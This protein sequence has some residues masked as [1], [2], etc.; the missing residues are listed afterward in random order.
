MG[1]SAGSGGVDVSKDTDLSSGG[2]D[3]GGLGGGG[4]RWWIRH[5]FPSIL[6]E[7]WKDF[8][9]NLPF[10]F[11]FYHDVFLVSLECG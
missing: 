11:N 1:L 6:E 8:P 4:T 9:N 10:F 2:D 3:G 5:K 7:L